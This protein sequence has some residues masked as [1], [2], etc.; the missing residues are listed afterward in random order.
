MSDE[1]YALRHHPRPNIVNGKLL[2]E[3]EDE[4]MIANEFSSDEE[5]DKDCKL[6]VSLTIYLTQDSCFYFVVILLCINHS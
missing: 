2:E 3:D 5:K 4:G 6:F 1:N